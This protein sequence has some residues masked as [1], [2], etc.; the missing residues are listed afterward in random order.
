MRDIFHFKYQNSYFE[1]EAVGIIGLSTKYL[2]LE[3]YFCKLE[4]ISVVHS[5]YTWEVYPITYIYYKK[6]SL[7]HMHSVCM[8][9]MVNKLQPPLQMCFTEHVWQTNSKFTNKG[10]RTDPQAAVTP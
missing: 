5:N 9:S 2:Y 1:D 8:S 10:L 4:S 6:L 7:F 3:V